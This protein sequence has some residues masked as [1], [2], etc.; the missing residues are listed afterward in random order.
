MDFL[1]TSIIPR[2]MVKLHKYIYNDQVWKTGMVLEEKLLFHSIAN[3]VLDRESKKINIEIKGN[4]NRDFLTV[5]RETLKE[6]NA[7]YQDLAV[8]EW[9]PLPELYKGEQLLVDYLELLGY[10][11]A[12]Q[13]Q[14]FSGKLRKAFPVSELL[15]GIEKPESRKASG[16]CQIFVSYSHK[17]EDYKEKL[18]EHLMPLVRLNK[19]TLWDDTSIDAGEEWR[20]KIFENLDKADIVLCLI[21]SSFIASEF[22]YTEEL[23][24]AL[25]VHDKGTKT[26]IPIRV[27]EVNWDKLK[28][29]KIQGLPANKWMSDITDNKSWTEIS[30]GIEEAIDR[31]KKM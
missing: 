28:I 12:G 16:S 27:Q 22:C 8:T 25:A 5:I 30:K 14:Y 10:E 1:P 4:R 7:T 23:A 29:A 13:E 15:N 26:V 11:E 19:A 3:I 20:A 18:L 31:I 6:I 2:L 17:D 9:I 21:S 24:H